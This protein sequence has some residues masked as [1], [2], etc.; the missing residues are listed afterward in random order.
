V[1]ANQLR[2]DSMLTPMLPYRKENAFVE[3]QMSFD[4]SEQFCAMEM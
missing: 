3:I 4:V 2:A 1:V